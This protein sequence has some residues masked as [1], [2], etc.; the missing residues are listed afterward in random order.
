MKDINLG[1]K[2]RDIVTGLEGIV[3]GKIEYINGCIQFCLTPKAG[4]NGIA[5]D[6]LWIDWQR[7][8]IKDDGVR[9]KFF[10]SRSGGPSSEAPTS[11]CG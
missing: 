11:Y 4:K 6:G 5:P 2:A 3:T 1:Q 7:V 9:N 10:S 8:E